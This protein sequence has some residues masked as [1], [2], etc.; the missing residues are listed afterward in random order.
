[1]SY[2]PFSSLEQF[3]DF[4]EVCRRFE[5]DLRSGV[6]TN[7][8]E[9]TARWPET[10]RTHV[11]EELLDL[12]RHHRQRRAVSGGSEL[13]TRD[14]D[15]RYSDTSLPPPDFG[16]SIASRQSFGRYRVVKPL[17]QG[18]FGRVYL[19]E[20]E[21]LKRA[22]AIKAPR[23]DRFATARAADAYLDE[24][25]TLAALKH[26]HILRVLDVG[27]DE[28]GAC[29]VVSEFIEGTDLEKRLKELPWPTP[30]EAARLTADIAD[31][32]HH[33]H[34]KGLVHRDV[35][36]A[37]ILI[38]STGRPV[39]AD[40]GL[41]LGDADF[42]SGARLAGT[43]AYMSPEQARSEG[44]LV[45]G[46]SD[47]FSLGVILYEMLTKRR[48][49]RSE[50]RDQL[51]EQ[52]QTAH[53]KP[54]RQVD[55]SIPKELERICLK[56]MA[57]Q[58]A[59]RY[60]TA[61]DMADDLERFLRAN[62]VSSP[63]AVSG[64]WSE[65]R[66]WLWV[67][68]GL[69][70]AVVLATVVAP[71]F[72]PIRDESTSVEPVATKSD[73]TPII[74][75]KVEVPLAKRYRGQVN[76][77]VERGPGRLLGLNDEGA[78]PL[79]KG[80]KF[81][82]E[83]E[84]IPAGYLYLV[85]VDPGHDVTPVYPWNPASGWGSRPATETP[86]DKLSLPT[87]PVNNRFRAPKAKAGV[88]TMVMFV[89]QTPLDVPEDVVRG[90][91]ENLPE[92]PLPEGGE[93]AAV[94]FDNFVEAYDAHRT[95]TFATVGTDDPFAKLQGQLKRALGDRIVFETAVSFARTDSK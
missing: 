71:R 79:R 33:A 58:P 54:P 36:P 93:Q 22:V 4:V 31:G 74:A 28:S 83:G 30:A 6:S 10:V 87:D 19:A 81:R 43:P 63:H 73:G 20:D 12:E 72:I 41:A 64:R 88:A 85:W 68:T 23:P 9:E 1:M 34:L 95:R 5:A 94:W 84:V 77:L 18:S 46:R 82:I 76:V 13:S 52:I 61:R 26:P 11:R 15:T 24:A 69:A 42:G 48:P 55:D 50:N 49:F 29:F 2:E 92:L 78:L 17:G 57:N 44:H 60:T 35:K 56:A 45:N 8:D 39:L 70:I 51:L 66:T 89:R 67:G 59:D 80:D 91:F 40:F 25:R 62:A 27:R 86:V 16:L 32:L 53:P 21:E 90:W 47:I 37:N 65:L 38:D 75:P 7:V 14:F 3:R